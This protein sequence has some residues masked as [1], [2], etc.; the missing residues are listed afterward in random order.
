MAEWS[1]APDSRHQYL[2]QI[3][4]FWSPI[5]GVGS[6]QQPQIHSQ[7]GRVILGDRLKLKH[8]PKIWDFWSPCG[9]VGSNPTPDNY[10]ERL[11]LNLTNLI[12]KET[13]M[14]C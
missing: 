10:F 13:I 6:N 4:D 1:K 12:I 7:D 3:W 11:N 8:L 2:P 14:L 5:G 9:G